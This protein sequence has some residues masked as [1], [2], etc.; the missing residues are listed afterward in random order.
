LFRTLAGLVFGGVL[1]GLSIIAAGAGHGSYIPMEISSAPIG[2]FGD[3]AAATGAPIVWGG[4]GALLGW[5]RTDHRKRVIPLVLIIHYASAA[6]IAAFGDWA[7][8]FRS[9]PAIGA[10][11][12]AWAAVYVIGQVAIWRSILARAKP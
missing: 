1:A 7:Y 8:L 5:L 2:L 3:M 4:V 12:F 11:I 10:I 6:I 9:M